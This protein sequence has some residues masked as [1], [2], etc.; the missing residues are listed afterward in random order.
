MNTSDFRYNFTQFF[1]VNVLQCYLETI[2]NN[3]TAAKVVKPFIFIPLK[4]L[5][6]N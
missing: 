1:N 2:N 4:F 6:R 3:S 5:V